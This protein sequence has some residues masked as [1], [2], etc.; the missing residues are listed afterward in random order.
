MDIFDIYKELYEIYG[1]QKWWPVKYNKNNPGFEISIGAILAQ[2]TS[3]KNVEKSLE[4]LNKNN[5][6]NPRSII[7]CPTK[8][9]QKCLRSAGYYRQKTKKLKIFSNWLDMNFGGDLKKFFIKRLIIARKELLS[10]WGIG[11]ETADSILLY[12]GNKPIF[13]ID[14]YTKRLCRQ[15]HHE[16]A[17][18]DAYQGYF[19]SNLPKSIRIYQEY[20][21][22]IVASGKDKH[23][24]ICRKIN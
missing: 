1:P 13:V 21:A 14:S 17:T 2:N 16:L 23:K 4:C 6:L 15:M 19:E 5:L 22:L 10:I 12:A 9:L 11:P 18:Y 3:W 24:K 7:K 8:K 20:H